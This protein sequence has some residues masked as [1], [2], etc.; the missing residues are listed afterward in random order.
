[1][2]K[3]DSAN[4]PDSK[5]LKYKATKYVRLSYTDD[6]EKESDSIINQ[7]RLIDDFVKDKADIE[8]VSEKIDDGY[9]GIILAEVR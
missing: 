8:I 6:K 5:V 1:M 7:S 4:Q 2:R 9:S 3:Y